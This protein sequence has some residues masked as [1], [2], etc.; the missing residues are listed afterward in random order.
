MMI[1]LPSLREV[2]DQYGLMAKKSLGQNFL[3]DQNITDKIIKLSL[4]AQR[5]ADFSNASVYEIGPGPGGLTRAIL[6]AKPQTLT[7][8][9]MDSRCIQIMQDLKNSG[10][11]QLRIVEGD[12]LRYDFLA[13]ELS[14]KNI[15]SNLPYNISVPLLLKWLRQIKEYQSL[16]LM[17]QK[18]VAER[19]MAI[20]NSKVYGR[21]SVLAQLMC[22]IKPLMNLH[23]ACFTPAPKIWSTVLLFVP[24]EQVPELVLLQ[25]VE[26]LTE[27]AFGQRRKMIRQSLKSVKNLEQ[28]CA[29]LQISPTARAENISP[30]QYLQ[31]AQSIMQ[32]Q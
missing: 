31:I 5:Q 21:I 10:Y 6:Q 28:I 29:K 13:D 16:T 9:E 8:I 19:I 12:A 15:V 1:K 18:E 22:Q 27:V 32:L 26:K 3:L 24:K 14:N 4:E 17:F 30:Q 25:M 23:P 7:V 2:V 20:P 11:P